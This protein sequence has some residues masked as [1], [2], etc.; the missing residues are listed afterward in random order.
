MYQ[1]SQ[2]YF[3]TLS[4]GMRTCTPSN[5]TSDNSYANIQA[6]RARP[7]DAGPA[8]GQSSSYILASNP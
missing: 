5:H 6:R 4:G 3:S 7:L 8:E 1:L 2:S